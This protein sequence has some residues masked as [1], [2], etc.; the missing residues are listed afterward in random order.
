MELTLAI[1]FIYPALEQRVALWCSCQPR[2]HCW[3]NSSSNS[4]D[5]TLLWVWK[6]CLCHPVGYG[7]WI[8]STWTLHS[9]V[10]GSHARS[11][12]STRRRPHTGAVC[13]CSSTALEKLAATSAGCGRPGAAA[14][15]PFPASS[16]LQRGSGWSWGMHSCGS[17]GFQQIRCY[18]LRERC[19]LSKMNHSILSTASSILPTWCWVHVA[20]VLCRR[21][22]TAA[23]RKGL[24]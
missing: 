6:T 4:K 14:A 7:K 10:T 23:C 3:S 13:A 11:L 20:D 17:L 24:L 9:Q 22:T 19:P 12:S 1:H 16:H 5:K 18:N 21:V 8:R 15:T 2:N